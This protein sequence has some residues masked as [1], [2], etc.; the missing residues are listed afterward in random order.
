MN[1]FAQAFDQIDFKKRGYFYG[2]EL[3]DYLIN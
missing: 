3:K 2:W 1:L